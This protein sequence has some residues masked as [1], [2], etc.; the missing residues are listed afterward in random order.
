[1]III[2]TDEQVQLAAIKVICDIAKR[3]GDSY[4]PLLPET[5]PFL[6]E[7]LEDEDEAVEKACRAAVQDLESVL[8]EEITKYF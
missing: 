4:L 5:I 1:M 3:L 7:L 6:S 2:I 8:G